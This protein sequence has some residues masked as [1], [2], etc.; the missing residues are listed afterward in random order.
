M[1]QPVPR[2]NLLLSPDQEIKD[3]VDIYRDTGGAAIITESLRVD[4]VDSSCG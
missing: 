3:Q 2:T 4:I 1:R